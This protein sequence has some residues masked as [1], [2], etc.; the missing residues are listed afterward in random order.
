MK[1]IIVI[2]ISVIITI[3]IISL[4]ISQIEKN[5]EE[6]SQIVETNE[7]GNMLKKIE[8][9]RVNNQETDEP[10][11]PSEREWNSVGPFSIDRSQYVL[12]EKIFVNIVGLDK[13]TKGYMTFT[14]IINNTHVFDYKKFNFDGSKPQQNFY[15]S[16][17]LF[18]KRGICT[19]EQITGDWEFR[20]YGN[21]GEY[22]SLEF[23]ILNQILPG[24][25]DRFEPVC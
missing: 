10:Y 5:N 13:N 25:E 9:K 6:T 15:L 3:A 11:A 4:S 21:N 18:D 17:E 16:I 22:G 1:N 14:K 19:I 7:I 2:S 23:K 20:V 24:E 8:E 12:G